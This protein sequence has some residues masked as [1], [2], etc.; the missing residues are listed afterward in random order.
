MLESKFKS[1]QREYFEARGWKFIQLVAGAGVPMGFPDTLCLSPLGYACYVEWKKSR[2]AKKQPLQI[3]W[4]QQLIKMGH[5]AFFVS[6]DNVHDWR[7]LMSQ[8]EIRC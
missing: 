3:F 7:Q 1:N 8:K 4:N 5:D 6:P 2:T